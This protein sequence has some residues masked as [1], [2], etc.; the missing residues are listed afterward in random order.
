M[1]TPDE[2]KVSRRPLKTKRGDVKTSKILLTMD[3][4][5]MRSLMRY[6]PRGITRQEMIR[7]VLTHY[8]FAKDMAR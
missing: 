5:L 7:Q 1:A 8:L 4:D 3:R 2:F 6:K